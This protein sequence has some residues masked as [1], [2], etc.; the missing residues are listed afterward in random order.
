[1]SVYGGRQEAVK[2]YRQDLILLSL[3]VMI[4]GLVAGGET[5]ARATA[6]DQVTVRIVGTDSIILDDYAVA[7]D[8]LADA[9]QSNDLTPDDGDCNPNALDAVLYATQQNGYD[10]P[11][12]SIY[13]DSDYQSYYINK[14]AGVEAKNP[15][16]WGTLM[17]S[18]DGCYD[19]NTLNMRAIAAGDTY[20]VYFDAHTAVG[21]NYGNQS[22]AS[23]G[24]KTAVG[25]AGETIKV[26]LQT[27]G[28]DEN[29]NPVSS[30]LGGATIYAAGPGW[31]D[32]TAVAVS[33]SSGQ[34]YI[35]FAAAGAYTLSLSENYYTYTRCTVNV[36]G[37]DV[38]LYDTRL[39][40]SDGANIL[41]AAVLFLTDVSGWSCSPY[42]ASAGAYVYRLTEGTYNFTAAAAGYESRHGTIVVSGETAQNINLNA[43][44]TYLV[45]LNSAG[46][47]GETTVLVANSHGEK[48]I[49]I[50]ASAG[51][52][53]YYLADDGYTYTIS[54]EGYHSAFGSFT[55]NG[56]AESLEVPVLHDQAAASPE[57][58]AWRKSHD[59]M[60]VTASPV[61]QGGWQAEEKW[62]ASLG[63]LGTWGT[64]STSNLIIYDD[65]LYVATEHGLSKINGS[66]GKLLKT[67]PL[68]ANASYVSQITYGGGQVYVT[69]AA[70]VDAFDA[71]TM[72]NVWSCSDFDTMGSS[73]MCTTSLLY[74]N[75]T[76]YV[77]SYG[78]STSN[79][80]GTYGG[81][82][83]ID[84]RNGQTQWNFWGGEDTVCYGAGAVIAGNYLVF[85]SDDEYLRAID[86][87]TVSCNAYNT[88]L[89]SPLSLKV[90]GAIRSA[91]VRADGYLYFTTKSGYIY[92]VSLSGQPVDWQ[93]EQSAR[94][95]NTATT[96][97]PLIYNG[98]IYVGANDGIYVLRADDLSTISYY[99]TRAPV[100]SSALLSTAYES[101]I[102]IYFTLNSAQS[103]IMVLT[104]DS[105]GIIYDTLYVPEH[106]QY[107]LNSLVA[108]DQG[109][110]YY[111]NDSGYV[112][113]V[114][115]NL[116]PSADLT[117]TMI[118]VTPE[119]I[120]S[121]A[122]T[123]YPLITVKDSSDREVTT[124]IPGSYYLPAGEY[125]YTVNLSGYQTAADRFTISAADVIAGRKEIAVVLTAQSS[126][127]GGG[128]VPSTLTVTFCLQDGA[129]AFSK[130][131]TVDKG[132]SVYDVFVK[133]MRAA[134][135]SYTF[136]NG[137]VKTIAG[138]SEGDRGVNSGWMYK[139]NDNHAQVG[140]SSYYVQAGDEIV[141]HFTTDY[142]REEDGQK[143]PSGS[144][145]DANLA[146][147]NAQ[148]EEKSAANLSTSA[149]FNDVS[150]NSWYFAAV[151]FVNEQG[152]F[153]GIDTR[154]F[155]PD[156]PMSRAMLVMVLARLNGADLSIFSNPTFADTQNNSWYA[157]AVA[158]SVANGI[159]QGLG[160]G[161]F[162]PDQ[163]IT[164]E[165]MCVMLIR[166][167]RLAGIQL[168]SAA[169]ADP[170]AD[171]GAISEWSRE[172]INMARQLGLIEGKDGNRFDPQGYLTRAEAATL[173]MRFMQKIVS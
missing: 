27:I 39:K 156:R 73:Y 94:F 49:C 146:D 93:L 42:S 8:T 53:Q 172:S 142:T 20:I 89:T 32:N 173:F 128:A 170:F 155:A 129:G 152:L 1:M 21:A 110:I 74:D 24:Q 65:Y 149:T 82:S 66:N 102:K 86:L 132:A 147:N 153:G 117:A 30:P 169:V 58:P 18:A 31:S 135:V 115:N 131:I 9:Q 123:I 26:A 10:R 50:S 145:N 112:L 57:W 143:W 159:V 154:V 67:T 136:N 19:G 54:R 164:R 88:L 33:D 163:E 78:C 14:L 111:S 109:V 126:D 133:A 121:G 40:V 6:A 29:W 56:A 137:Y 16:Y 11:S 167:C 63:D 34:A 90:N 116:R 150:E 62:S 125:S 151:N 23:F 3:L 4:L 13:Y 114:K 148:S 162:G 140:I 87:S 161:R 48:Q 36:A 92:K 5:V 84:A 171:D 157:A 168:P 158:W 15:D 12:Y 118:R 96:S 41:S 85:G 43:R 100:Q 46:N 68:S 160:K 47:E 134:E 83:A 104:D 141:F 81:Y 95:T 113:A 119:V 101:K 80:L 79:N 60:A 55:V 22:Y 122:S 106:S 144:S 103:E 139:V 166:Y 69:T 108:D 77:G 44:A 91:I 59:N 52:F 70:G 25:N 72:E 107:C 105:T 35:K 98:L 17:V 71:L 64:L 130:S 2:I 28:Y 99:T 38:T 120:Q 51:V 138:L 97:T 45:T 37:S 7:M 61:A 124:L 127:S 76:V 75:G 165:Q